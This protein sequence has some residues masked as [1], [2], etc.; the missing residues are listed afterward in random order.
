MLRTALLPFARVLSCFALCLPAQLQATPLLAFTFS[1]SPDIPGFQAVPEIL[2]YSDERGFGWESISANSGTAKL[3]SVRLPEGNYKVTATI[4]SASHDADTTIKAELRRLMLENIHTT[5]NS[6]R[7]LTFIVNIRRPEIASG[8]K[9]RLNSPREAVHEII[10]WD[11]K[12]TLEINGKNPALAAISVEPVKVPTLFLLGD[13]T[14]TDQAFEPY[15]SWGQMLPRFLRPDIAVANH[16]QSGESLQSSTNA[17]RLDKVLSLAQPGDFVMIQFGHN[18]M[19]SKAPNALA[20]YQA[21][22]TDWITKARA[23]GLSP[24]LI[25]SVHRHTFE[26]PKITNSL[27]DYPETVRQVAR[28]THCPLI[29]LHSMSAAFYEALGPNHAIHAF[30]H[31]AIPDPKF[32]RTH[33]S[34]YGAYELA[35]C[36]VQGIRANVPEL[37]QHIAPEIP[38]FSPST[39]SPAEKFNLPTSPRHTKDKPLGN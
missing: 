23:A 5:A 13:S 9:V 36:V 24:I 2:P 25:T 26:G 27:G 8:G 17:R 18:D 20:K 4:G 16:A 21:L 12:L 30:K 32:D 28:T 10:A 34:P 3:F 15:A 22:L 29:D 6:T 1:P 37:A 35:K 19:K 14:V 7:N 11:D 31:D 33:H 39:P 38:E